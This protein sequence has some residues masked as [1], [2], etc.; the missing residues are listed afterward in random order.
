MGLPFDE[1]AALLSP[2]VRRILLCLPEKVRADAREIRLRTGGP[3]M[4]TGPEGPLFVTADT[5]AVSK[6]EGTLFETDRFDLFECFRSLCNYS[7]HSYQHEINSGFITVKGG[8]RAGVCGTAVI[9][10]GRITNVKNISSINLRIA[11]Q[12]PGAAQPL[13]DFLRREGLQG[14]VLV[15]A[16]S[17]GKTT[18]LR[19]LCR[20]LS[21]GALDRLYR[22]ALVDERGEL[23]AVA[24]GAP[25]FDL[26]YATDCLYGYPKQLGIEI[27]IRTLSPEVIVF[28]EIGSR[29]E[30]NAVVDGVNAGA[31]VFASLHAGSPEEFLK[32][33]MAAPLLH[34]QAFRLFFFL[35]SWKNPCHIQSIKTREELQREAFGDP[36]GSVLSDPYRHTDGGA[37]T[38]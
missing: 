31:V 9:E 8:H 25:A 19:D 20:Q 28:D 14:A 37:I 15:G 30:L 13:I 4:L 38:S 24:A 27:A 12:V 11:R 17:S 7:V 16:P 5:R 6:P 32:R 1:A 35:D 33:P 21:S 34:C 29:G 36:S 10:G 23:S 18:M 2:R 3:V 22:T 26:G